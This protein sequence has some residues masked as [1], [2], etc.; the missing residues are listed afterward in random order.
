[1]SI[2]IR[3]LVWA[4]FMVGVLG[5]SSD[6]DDSEN[7]SDSGSGGGTAAGT[8]GASEATGGTASGGGNVGG[9]AATGGSGGSTSLTDCGGNTCGEEQL[10]V[11]FRDGYALGFGADSYDACADRPEGCGICSCPSIEGAPITGCVATNP[12]DVT[13]AT[14]NCGDAPCAQ[15][16]VCLVDRSGTNPRTCVPLPNGCIVDTEFCDSGCPAQVA[17]A[18]GLTYSTCKLVADQ[19]GV[20]VEPSP[21]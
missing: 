14:A 6:G 2:G 19:A 17:E 1:M 5:C 3:R 20:Y 16:E 10:C 15:G 11:T 21:R 9:G 7:A 13:A 4:A 18:E 12:P 8:T